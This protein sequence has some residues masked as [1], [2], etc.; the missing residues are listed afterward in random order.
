MSNYSRLVIDCNR[1]PGA[2]DSIPSVSDGIVIPGNASLSDEQTAQRRAELFDP[3]HDAIRACLDARVGR[4]TRLLSIHS[5][6]PSLGECER[7]WSIGVCYRLDQ[8][9]AGQWLSALRRRT[10][11]PVGDNEPYEI[12]EQI[13]Y[14]LPH[15]GE[16]RRLPGLMLEVRQDKLRDSASIWRWCELLAD[17]HQSMR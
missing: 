9:W 1:D 4:A 10:T 2:P 12:E 5:F 17:C 3:Y 6:T 16:R 7:P 14:T 15:H 8:Q 13:D 11:D